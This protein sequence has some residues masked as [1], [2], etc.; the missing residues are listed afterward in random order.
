MSLAVAAAVVATLIVSGVIP[1]QPKPATGGVPFSDA[2][3]AS[4]AALAHLSGGPWTT[5]VG[6]VGV[7]VPTGTNVS[8]ANATSLLGTN[9]TLGPVNGTPVASTLHVSAFSGQFD[10]GLA[11]FWLVILTNG[12]KTGFVAVD[13]EDQNAT[14]FATLA[15]DGCLPSGSSAKTLPEVMLDSPSAAGDAWND[16]GNGW[17]AA[18]H[19]LTSQL[20]VAYPGGSFEGFPIQIPAV[21]AMVYAPCN[22]LL[23]GSS[24]EPGFIAAVGLT[25]GS[26]LDGI[27]HDVSCPA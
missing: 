13:V 8:A 3:A 6:A 12:T 9:C 1:L 2:R 20:M 10:S 24:S 17:A 5:V 22:P 19:N 26:P 4:L 23:G 14:A 11:P 25:S 21:W 18:D 7:D 15:G 27:S 16:F